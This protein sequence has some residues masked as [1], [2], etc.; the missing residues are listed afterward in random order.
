MPRHRLGETLAELLAARAGVVHQPLALDDVQVDQ[1]GG[2]ARRMPGVREHVLERAVGA[3]QERVGHPPRRDRAAVREV[4]RR[5]P[6]REAHDVRGDAEVVGA[7]PGAEPPEAGDDLVEDQ[8]HAVAVA[9][10]PHTR[11]VAG[12]RHDAAQRLRDR[13][14]DEGAHRLGAVEQDRPPPAPG[15]RAPRTPPGCGRR[16][17]SGTGSAGRCAPRARASAGS[18]CAGTPGGRPATACRRS[19][20]GTSRGA[21]SP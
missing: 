20:R 12:A 13:L 2:R 16:T 3:A 1:A 7:E 18:R 14:A 8:E 21:R 4:A 6:L 10:L 11:P 5:D 9:D 19:R 17:R 15:R